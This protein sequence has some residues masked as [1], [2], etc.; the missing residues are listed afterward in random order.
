MRPCRRRS[1]SGSLAVRRPFETKRSA[2]SKAAALPFNCATRPSQSMARAAAKTPSRASRR[3]PACARA[4]LC[5][6]WISRTR[7][8][9]SSA[10][11]AA[12]S[13]AKCPMPRA[14]HDGHGPWAARDRKARRGETGQAP[15]QIE[16]VILGQRCRPPWKPLPFGRGEVTS[17]QVNLTICPT[18]SRA[19]RRAAY[20][21]GNCFSGLTSGTP[22]G[23]KW[24]SFAVRMVKPRTAAV[25]AIAMSSNPGLWA[26][27][28]SR[29][30]PA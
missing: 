26:R 30:A 18:A 3:A 24:R 2:P 9:V 29:M 15:F 21:G 1:L 8:G 4:K 14:A 11:R 6:K 22:S 27:A 5:E 17:I 20:H 19:Q 23:T 7:C 10:I 16:L 13:R 25:A 28:R 12:S